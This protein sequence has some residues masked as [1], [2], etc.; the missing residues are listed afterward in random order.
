MQLSIKYLVRKYFILFG[1]EFLSDKFIF[2]ISCV[3]FQQHTALALILKRPYFWIRKVRILRWLVYDQQVS[4]LYK[5][6]ENV[7]QSLNI[8]GT[9]LLIDL[10]TKIIFSNVIL[11]PNF[12]ML[13][14]EKSGLE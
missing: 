11:L 7:N 5:F 14:E 8:E 13:F 2:N 6:P 10:L 12:K 1:V 3:E 4:H 9:C